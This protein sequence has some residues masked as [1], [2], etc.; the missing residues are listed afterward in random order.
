MF[1]SVV[2]LSPIP[3]HYTG[4]LLYVC[5]RT[6]MSMSGFLIFLKFCK[7]LKS[8][9]LSA[10]FVSLTQILVKSSAYIVSQRTR[11]L[12]NIFINILLRVAEVN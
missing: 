8:T 10:G 3:N 1:A 7:V 11:S 4:K 2:N 6:R 12:F 5:A 9:S